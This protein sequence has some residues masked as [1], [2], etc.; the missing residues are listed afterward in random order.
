MTDQ[1]AEDFRLS[2]SKTKTFN[3]CKKQYQFN[4]LLKFPKKDRDYHTF[5]KFC[6]KVLE[7]FHSAY[8]NGCQLP[9]HTK[10]SEA[11]KAAWAEY[12]EKMTPEMKKEC[13][14][15]VDYY[16]R[17][18]TTHKE[19]NLPA[20][21]IAVEKRFEFPIADNIIL[22]GAIDRIQ[23]DADDVLHVAD[24]KT[25][26]NKKYLKNDWFQLLT[27][28]YVML[29]E[30]PSIKKVRASYILLRH[31]FEYI[32]TE[33]TVKEIK[34][35]KSKFLDVA[36]QMKTETEF[37]PTTSALCNYCDFLEHCPEGKAKSFNKQVYGEI[38]Y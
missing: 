26:K 27:Y 37:K 2:V 19:K 25:T 1:Q 17:N 38:A 22:N 33:F 21:V 36:Q 32:T 29:S 34:Q 30:D 31:N 11:W 16:L 24:Y 18:I 8:L 15:L 10:M 3:Q 28:A 35:I 7:E 4:Y 9:Y 13:W 6:H 14:A 20:N 12:K 5:G 23:L